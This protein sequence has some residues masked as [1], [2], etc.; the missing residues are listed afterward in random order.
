MSKRIIIGVVSVI[1][2]LLLVIGGSLLSTLKRYEKI[3]S[4]VVIETPDLSRVSDGTYNGSFEAILIS[5]DVSVTVKNHSITGVDLVSHKNGRGARAE[6]ITDKVVSAQSLE[7]DTITG[8][9][10]SCLVILKAIENA[11]N[12]GLSN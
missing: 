8:A 1:I 6:V 10:N 3:I 9:T 7:V 4:D 5:A 12:A 11:L 2:V